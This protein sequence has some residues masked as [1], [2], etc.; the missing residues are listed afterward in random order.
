MSI[1]SYMFYEYDKKIVLQI[2]IAIRS[3]FFSRLRHFF[4]MLTSFMNMS[5]ATTSLAIGWWTRR[6]RTYTDVYGRRRAS[7]S[8]DGRRRAWCERAGLSACVPYRRRRRRARCEWALSRYKLINTVH[9]RLDYSLHT[10]FFYKIRRQNWRWKC[11]KE[12]C[13]TGK[14]GTR[15]SNGKLKRQDC[16]NF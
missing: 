15:K 16:R 3:W 11:G 4:V 7:T 9:S 6:R 13:K 10:T 5:R 14:C 8:I 2:G 1:G 12:N